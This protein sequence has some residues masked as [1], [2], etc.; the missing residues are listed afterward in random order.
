MKDIQYSRLAAIFFLIALIITYSALLT[1]AGEPRIM[2]FLF[3][4][5]WAT[6]QQIMKNFLARKNT[7][8]GCKPWLIPEQRCSFIN[9]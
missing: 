1:I 5:P 3:S 4:P 8:N 7:I 9:G 6:E 2:A